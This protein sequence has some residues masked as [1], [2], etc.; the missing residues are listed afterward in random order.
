MLLELLREKLINTNILLYTP[1]IFE[2]ILYYDK[3]TGTILYMIC[4]ENIIIYD[5]NNEFKFIK[6]NKKE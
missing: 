2:E 4:K 6:E 5:K 3:I 1:D